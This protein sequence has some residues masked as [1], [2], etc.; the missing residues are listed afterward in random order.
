MPLTCHCRF[1]M[2]K[3]T[4]KLQFNK[5]TIRILEGNQLAGVAGGAPTAQCTQV[6]QDCSGTDRCPTS[7]HN[8]PGG[9]GCHSGFAVGC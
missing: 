5:T 8:L 3:T 1:A 2:K 9:P 7:T 4:T 6:G